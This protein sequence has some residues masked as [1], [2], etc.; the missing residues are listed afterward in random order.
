MKDDFDI[1]FMPGKT[2]DV[3]MKLNTAKFI[4]QFSLVGGTALSVQIRHRLSEDLDF[5]YDGEELNSNLIKRNIGKLF[6][7]YRIIRQDHNWQVDLLIDE[8]KLSFF[9]TGAV[10]VPF[11]VRS[12]SFSVGQINIAVTK[13]IAALKFSAIAQRNT[14]RDY[15]DLYCLSKY[16]FSLLELIE[17]TRKTVPGLS[18]V[19]YTETLIYTRDI[20]ENS[21]SSHLSPAENIDKHQIA[22]FF[23][24]ELIKIRE[25][26]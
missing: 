4:S 7:G 8:V 2:R 10:S 9:S 23:S 1:G 14:I 18:P 25:Q 22:D 3:F 6:P 21:I 5:I 16:H 12:Y 11:N 17:F 20:D 19:T 13:A 15:Y 24:A 26:I